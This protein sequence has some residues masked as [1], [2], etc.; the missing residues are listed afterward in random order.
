MQ[1]DLQTGR[2]LL[3]GA[4]PGPADL[5]TLRALRAIEGAGALLY[6]ALVDETVV[7]LA[8]AGCVR[9][10]TGKRA[11]AASMPHRPVNTTSVITRGLVSARKSRQSAGRAGEAA[12]AVMTRGRYRSAAGC[13][14]EHA[15]PHW[16]LSRFLSLNTDV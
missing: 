16:R 7:A 6:D 13:R 8:P 5:L 11:G 2:V 4:G 12:E 3:V 10:Q 15:P 9:I 1:P 14:E